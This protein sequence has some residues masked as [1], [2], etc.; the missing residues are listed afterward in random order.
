MYL[1]MLLP[2]ACPEQSL[3]LE[4]SFDGTCNT[5]SIRNY[6]PLGVHCS[7]IR[8]EGELSVLAADIGT[9]Q[10]RALCFSG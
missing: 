10:K 2:S 5:R 8:S 7:E 3:E 4:R 6:H 9:L 1:E